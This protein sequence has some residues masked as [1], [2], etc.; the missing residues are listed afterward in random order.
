MKSLNEILLGGADKEAVIAEVAQMI[1]AHVA[2]RGGLRGI[3]LRTGFKMLKAAK[4][5]IVERASAKLLPEFLEA[6][7]PL[8]RQFAE[9]AAKGDFAAHLQ[10]HYAAASKALIGVADRRVARA[11][12]TVQSYYE[13]FGKDAEEHVRDLLPSLARIIARRLR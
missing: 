12:P 7:E 6:L 11:N 3:A 4:P 10:R 2:S 5:G 13:K 8:H 9:G 1:E